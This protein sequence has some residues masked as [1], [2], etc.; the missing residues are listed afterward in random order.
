MRN[1]HNWFSFNTTKNKIFVAGNKA[2]YVISGPST[3]L[4]IVL[5]QH[6]DGADEIY[7]KV[8]A[9]P[10]PHFPFH[11]YRLIILLW[12]EFLLLGSDRNHTRLLKCVHC[13]RFLLTPLIQILRIN[14]HVNYTYVHCYVCHSQYMKLEPLITD[15]GSILCSLFAFIWYM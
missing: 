6:K 13:S 1:F 12:T 4:T 9:Y 15:R 5:N 3:F 2:D 10:C 7:S 11:I 8:I 14:I